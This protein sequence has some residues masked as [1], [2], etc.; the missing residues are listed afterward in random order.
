MNYQVRIKKKAA[1]GLHRLPSG[2]LKLLFLLIADLQADGPV[3]KSWQNFSPLG[4]DSYHCHLNYRY[5]ACW[6]CRKNELARE[7]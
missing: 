5:A 4:P 6:T 7:V 3:Q 1:R 2:V